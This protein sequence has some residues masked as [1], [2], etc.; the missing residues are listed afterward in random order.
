M[1]QPQPR[2]A[3]P[4]PGRGLAA[5]TLAGAGSKIGPVLGDLWTRVADRLIGERLEGGWRHVLWTRAR[6][7]SS[8]SLP[9]LSAPHAADDPTALGLVQE[10][11]REA[12]VLKQQ[13]AQAAA[14]VRGLY[15]E[16][17]GLRERLGLPPPEAPAPAPEA[18]LLEAAGA[19]GVDAEGSGSWDGPESG[20][21]EPDAESLGMPAAEEHAPMEADD[22][23]VVDSPTMPD[24]VEAPSEEAKKDR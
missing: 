9:P 7:F 22:E 18:L 10:A 24:R 23:S 8:C 4:A 20:A 13:L 16:N 15:A 5:S 1:A 12:D 19:G 2:P 14:L 17:A 3:V 21:E 6:I 11:Q